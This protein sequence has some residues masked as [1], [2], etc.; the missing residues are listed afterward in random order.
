[1]SSHIAVDST[2]LD[3][4]SPGQPTVESIDAEGDLLLMVGSGAVQRHLR[5]SSHALCRVSPVFKRMLNSRFLEGTSRASNG[6]RSISLPD[7]NVAAVTVLCDIAHLRCGSV[8]VT[9]FSLLNDLAILCDKYDTSEALQ[10]WVEVWFSTRFHFRFR[11]PPGIDLREQLPQKYGQ[12]IYIAYCYNHENGFAVASRNFLWRATAADVSNIDQ[13]A[14]G[15][16]V[17]PD[18][19]LGEYL[20]LTRLFGN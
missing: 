10:P 5:V 8:K 4:N 15:F 17:L 13:N 14:P 16:A 19:F 1:M 18:G 3:M 12:C 9:S 6:L 7:D 2:D 11:Y 20:P